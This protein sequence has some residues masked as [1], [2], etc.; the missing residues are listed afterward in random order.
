M[1]KFMHNSFKIVVS[2]YVNYRIESF[3]EY[4][5]TQYRETMFWSLFYWTDIE[6]I[7]NY[8]KTQNNYIK[9]IKNLIYKRLSSEIFWKFMLSS[10][11][12][13][14][15]YYTYFRLNNFNVKIVCKQ[16]NQEKYILV[17]DISITNR[18]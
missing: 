18:R 1:T 11:E 12:T 16:N 6:L 8:C 17:E 2:K 3:F 13:I 10:D 15:E 5:K 9:T 14:E 4:L 7:D